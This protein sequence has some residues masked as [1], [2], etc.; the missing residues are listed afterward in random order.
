MVNWLFFVLFWPSFAGF[1]LCFY[2]SIEKTPFATGISKTLLPA[3]GKNPGWAAG[4]YRV[5]ALQQ[6]F[7]QLQ[8]ADRN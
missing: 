4:S 7:A 8:A 2:C 1:W 3:I 6:L 5:F